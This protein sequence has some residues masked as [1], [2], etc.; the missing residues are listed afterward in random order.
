[1]RKKKNP[2]LLPMLLFV[3]VL[4]LS[5]GGLI[6]AQNLRKAEIEKPKQYSNQDEIPRVTIQEAYKAAENGEA[7]II[8][9]RSASEFSRQHVTGAVNLP[10]DQV[11][12]MLGELDPD[13][14]YLT[15]CT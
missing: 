3:G 2:L 13:I 7:V 15:Y 4:V 5:I 12:S 11:E 6:L 8:D 1:M 14:W 9:T 10:A